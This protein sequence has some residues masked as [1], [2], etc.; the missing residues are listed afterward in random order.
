MEKT[1]CNPTPLPDYP[2]GRSCF[3]RDKEI[4]FRETADPSVIYEDGKWYLYS[5][6]G[7]VYWS[8]DFC[9]WNHKRIEPYDCGYAPTVVNHKGKYYLCGSISDLYVSDDPLSDFT[10][11]GT[12]TLPSGEKLPTAFLSDSSSRLCYTWQRGSGRSCGPPG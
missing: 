10:K 8:D 2:V 9:T 12:F 1:Y 5:S 7:I 4:T 6:C 11:I 3:Y